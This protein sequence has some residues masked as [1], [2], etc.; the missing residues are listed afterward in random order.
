MAAPSPT[1]L[2]TAPAAPRV[3]EN[4]NNNNN[5]NQ[6]PRVVVETTPFTALDRLRNR[7]ATKSVQNSDWPSG[8]RTKTVQRS[9]YPGYLIRAI[10]FLNL[11]LV[12]SHRNLTL[13]MNN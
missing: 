12:C 3:G 11:N 5:G 1:V 8:I 4:N 10:Q 2:E 6:S 9:I 13:C 7:L